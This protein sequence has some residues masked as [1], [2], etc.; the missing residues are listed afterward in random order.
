MLTAEQNLYQAQS[1]LASASGNRL[2][3]P[4]VGL[5]VARRRMADTGGERIRECRNARRNAQPDKLGQTAAACRPAAA[6]GPGS[7][8][9]LPTGDRT[10][11]HRSGEVVVR[12]PPRM[13]RWRQ[14]GGRRV[15][16]RVFAVALAVM[17][18]LRSDRSA[19]PGSRPLVGR[20]RPGSQA[21]SDGGTGARCADASAA[22]A[23]PTAV[24]PSR[25]A[26]TAPPAHRAG[27]V[28]GRRRR[29]SRS[30]RPKVQTV[31]D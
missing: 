27:A 19:P 12:I 9:R 3:G 7:S 15:S 22:S 30:C 23:A 18:G 25:T 13:H 28:P 11:G 26:S 2:N 10:C 20:L 6:A 31:S 29:R 14:P 16:G 24:Q 5:P 17:I 1:N 21:R 8:R 4:R